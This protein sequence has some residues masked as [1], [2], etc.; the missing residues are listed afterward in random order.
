MSDSQPDWKR[1]YP[2]ESNYLA[3]KQ[4]R[5]NYVDEGSGRPMIMVHGNP[6]WSFYY[7]EIVK[8]FR[9]RFRTIAVDHIGCGLSDK[10]QDADY[11]LD[12]HIE[13]LSE[14][15][16]SLDLQEATLIAHDWGGAI[17][18]GAL[19]ANQDRFSRIVL[20]NTGAFPPPYI[21]WR[22]RVCRIP[23]LGKLGV[24]GFN[25]FARAAITMATTQKGGLQKRV[26]NGLL[27]PYNNWQNR[28]A[29]YNFVKDIPTKPSQR[30]W[31]TLDRM[32]KSLADLPMK[33]LLVWGMKDW[34]F[35]PDCLARFEKHWPDAES[36]RIESG[37]HY[38]LEDAP[39]EVIGAIENFVS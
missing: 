9:D 16:R 17:G 24:Q 31:Q 5:M 30:T 3:L 8:R 11:T 36:L 22:I 39:H 38:V 37:G 4:G 7:R 27:A 25:L 35:R 32:E 2:F 20:L 33:K 26:A 1:E 34:C 13:N 28:K 23:L 21:P 29:I 18:L 15:I 12:Q 10:P 19:L 14:L 6:T